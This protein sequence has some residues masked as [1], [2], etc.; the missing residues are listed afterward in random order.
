VIDTETTLDTSIENGNASGKEKK[1]VTTR[2]CIAGGPKTMIKM[3][4]AASIMIAIDTILIDTITTKVKATTA[5]T[6]SLPTT[7]TTATT[8]GSDGS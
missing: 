5:K 4:T 1:L 8:N 3:G 7:T 2:D 6:T